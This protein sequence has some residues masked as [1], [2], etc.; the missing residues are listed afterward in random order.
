MFRALVDH[1]KL[2]TKQHHNPYAIGWIKKGPSI[3]VKDLCHVPI[4]FSKFYQDFVACDIVDMD[5]CHVLL[6]RPWQHDVDAT[7]KGKENIYIFTWKGKR[8]VMKPITPTPKSAKQRM[9][10][11][12][13]ICDR[14]K[15]RFWDQNFPPTEFA[16][17]DSAHGSID[18]N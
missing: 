3:T 12:V 15:S 16:K 2:D 17:D 6:G 9:F 14:G 4:F 13:S 7:H 5:K 18:W 10:K 8:I 11:L 1:L